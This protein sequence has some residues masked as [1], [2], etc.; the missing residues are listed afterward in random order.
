MCTSSVW[1][2][3]QPRPRSHWPSNHAVELTHC[4]W[5]LWVSLS[6]AVFSLAVFIWLSLAVSFLIVSALWLFL[7]ASF[8]VSLSLC[9]FSAC[10]YLTISICLLYDCPW[11]SS[12]LLTLGSLGTWDFIFVSKPEAYNL[13]LW[14][15]WMLGWD[16]EQ[17]LPL[18]TTGI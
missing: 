9:L 14:E 10:F 18:P 5:K 12:C 7:A 1:A 15:F 6:Q 11:S 17:A 8:R 16:C 13:H 2:L 3:L 4:F